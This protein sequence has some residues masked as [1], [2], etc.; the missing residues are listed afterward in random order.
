MPFR[1]SLYFI[2]SLCTL[3]IFASPW[4]KTGTPKLA[5]I[6]N[7]SPEI[8]QEHKLVSCNYFC[9]KSPINFPLWFVF[10]FPI[11]GI[12]SVFVILVLTITQSLLQVNFFCPCPSQ[13][14]W[15]HGK[16]YYLWLCH[17]LTT[18]AL[19]SVTQGRIFGS[20]Y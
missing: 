14:L 19:K 2:L 5:G 10:F 1:N 6:L 9:S 3:H 20:R 11:T 12:F 17:S 15:F 4:K 18:Y 13:L 7:C 16:F 8:L